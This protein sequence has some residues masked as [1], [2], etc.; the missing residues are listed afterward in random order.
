MGGKFG[1]QRLIFIFAFLCDAKNFA[2]MG[3]FET[4]PHI[5]LTEIY[6]SMYPGL[7][8]SLLPLSVVGMVDQMCCEI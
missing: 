3:K 2:L 4:Q 7:P 5:A 8:S 6:N 1:V